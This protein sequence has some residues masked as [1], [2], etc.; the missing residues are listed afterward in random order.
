MAQEIFMKQEEEETE[1]SPEELKDL[2]GSGEVRPGLEPNP[3]EGPGVPYFR[4][5]EFNDEPVKS[6]AEKFTNFFAPKPKKDKNAGFKEGSSDEKKPTHNKKRKQGGETVGA[7][8]NILG[9]FVSRVPNHVGTGRML[10]WQS[11]ATGEILDD[12]LK[13]TFIDRALIQPAVGAQGKFDVIRAVL[14][15]P[16]LVFAIES[17]PDMAPILMPQLVSSLREALPLMVKPIQKAKKKAEDYDEAVKKLYPDAKEGF[18]PI[19]DLL[20][21][22]F[23]PEFF[24]QTEEEE[25]QN[26]PN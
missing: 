24:T 5:E 20:T 3:S 22:L 13:D 6:M 2:G 9:S 8:I 21:Q 25:E 23:P 14:A 10:Q 16:I 11:L 12:Q 7:F 19:S 26:E 4:D 17:R 18:D 15:P 1:E